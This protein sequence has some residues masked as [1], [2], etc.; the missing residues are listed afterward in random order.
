MKLY[1]SARVVVVPSIY[2]PFGMTALE[3]MS[4]KR[5]VVVSD[6]GGL[7]DIVV[8]KE[9]GY[10]AA[11]KSYLDLAQWIMALLADE[12]RRNLLAKMAHDRAESEIY[13][14]NSIAN[15]V[16]DQYRILL[17]EKEKMSFSVTD[18]IKKIISQIKKLAEEMEPTLKNPE[19]K[20]IKEVFDWAGEE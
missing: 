9:T 1:Q 20:I 15:R 8:H 6:T 10:L 16:I 13:S 7:R 4:C 19:N 18:E 3:A 14:W 12:D 5:P 17:N 11:P 2:E